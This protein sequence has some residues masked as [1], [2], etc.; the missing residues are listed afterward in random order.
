MTTTAATEPF[1]P[2]RPLAERL[3]QAAV[4]VLL[5]AISAVFFV[6]FLWSVST[7]FKTL[8]DTAY[9]SLLRGNG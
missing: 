2:A 9:F 6:P 4:Y 1:I 7:S 5:L 3:R 8:P